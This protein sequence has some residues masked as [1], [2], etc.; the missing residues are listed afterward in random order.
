MRSLIPLVLIAAFGQSCLGQGAGGVVQGPSCESLASTPGGAQRTCNNPRCTKCR[1]KICVNVPD[2]I[3][4]ERPCG[5][6]VPR[7]VTPPSQPREAEG[8]QGQQGFQETGAYIAPPRTGSMRGATNYRGVD[9]GSI[10]FPELRLR[11]PCIELPACFKSRSGARMH[12]DSAVAP[13]ES[14][15]FVATGAG[16]GNAAL[17]QRIASLEDELKKRDAQQPNTGDA[18][19]RAA[20]E[21]NAAAESRSLPTPSRAACR[22]SSSRKLPPAM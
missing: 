22:R 7:D 2:T 1:P 13:W 20:V 9:G 8:P 11:L 19:D 18:S 4:I 10:T 12:I 17:H 6:D 15:G 3:K 14:H 16:G 5:K 21:R